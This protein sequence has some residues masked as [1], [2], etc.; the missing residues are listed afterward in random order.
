MS[1]TIRAARADVEEG[2]RFAGYF[3]VAGD[4]L[5]RW[6]FGKR[7]VE[8]LT[9]A[10]LQRG[11]DLSYE[12]VWFAEVDDA[13]AG[14]LSGYSAADHRRSQDGPLFRA[15]GVRSI[16]LVSTWLAAVR[17]FSFMKQLPDGDWYVQTVAVDE[18]HRGA[19]L[20]SR[21]LDHAEKVAAAAGSCRLALD[22]A[23]GNDGAKRLYQR[24]GMA[25]EATSAHVPFVPGTAV[26]RMVK[27]L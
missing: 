26:E 24:R 18:A 21:L 6:M 14:M 13:I 22:V 7:Y 12:H 20:G 2:E 3:N 23:V 1:M 5:A 15:A 19:G 11:H 27:V 4:G 17:L 9:G 25:V 8:I 10:Y 16:R